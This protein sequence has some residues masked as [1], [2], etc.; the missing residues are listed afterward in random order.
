MFYLQGF[1]A[2]VVSDGAVLHVV[3][4]IRMHVKKVHHLVGVN[5]AFE[6]ED[7]KSTG[8]GNLQVIG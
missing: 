1:K 2:N 3:V 4:L 6:E 8:P 7:K 5:C